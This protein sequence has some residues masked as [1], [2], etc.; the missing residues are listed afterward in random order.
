MIEK[1]EKIKMRNY[2]LNPKGRK[3]YNIQQMTERPVPEVMTNRKSADDLID[4][5]M[6]EQQERDKMSIEKTRTSMKEGMTKQL[7]Q[8]AF[9]TQEK[10]L[11]GRNDLNPMSSGG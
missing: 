8:Y 9:H 5:L 3:R 6:K 10:R 4:Q 11:N 7:S 1:I 2:S